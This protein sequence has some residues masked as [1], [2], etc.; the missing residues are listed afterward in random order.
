M[1]CYLISYELRHPGRNYSPF[2]KAIE[3]Y[4]TWAQL[5]ESSCAVRTRLSASEVLC[6]LM[7]F[8]DE[9]DRLFVLKSDKDAAWVNVICKSGWLQEYL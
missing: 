9:D 8:L 7:G 5:T 1:S 6:S 2:Y 3:D 4:G